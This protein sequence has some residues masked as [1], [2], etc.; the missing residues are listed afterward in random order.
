[1]KLKISPKKENKELNVLLVE[2]NPINRR[3]A[4]LYLKSLGHHY[5]TATNG[6]IALD[7]FS[8]NKYDLIIMDVN[9]PVM[10]GIEATKKIREMEKNMNPTNKTKIFALTSNEYESSEMDCYNAGMDEFKQKPIS[11]EE[12]SK[13]LTIA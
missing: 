2:D 8:H 4:E 10:D 6:E 3:I 12:F 5:D 7:K 13:Y 11:I 9:M 1:M